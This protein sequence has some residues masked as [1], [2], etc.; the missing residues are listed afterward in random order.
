VT[1]WVYILTFELEDYMLEQ[2][3]IEQF[4]KDVLKK[5]SEVADAYGVSYE[6]IPTPDILVKHL[7]PKERDGRE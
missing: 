4:D 2:Q 5:I 3:Y 1:T 6:L 7:F